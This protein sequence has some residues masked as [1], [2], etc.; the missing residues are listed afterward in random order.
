MNHKNIYTEA[1]KSAI[2]HGDGPAVVFAGPGSGK[3]FVLTERIFYMIYTLGIKPEHILVITFTKAA[4]KQMKARFYNKSKENLPITFKTFHAFFYQILSQSKIH[5]HKKIIS[6][7]EKMQII[8]QII[9]LYYS[10]ESDQS[11]LIKEISACLSNRYH[12]S[13]NNIY[14][15]FSEKEMHEMI[16]F[17]EEEKEKINRIDFTDLVFLSLGKLK[18]DPKFL[19]VIQK[20]YPYILIDEFQDIT[21]EQY[22]IICLIASKSKNIFIV[23]D[24]D[25]SIYKF[26]GSKSNCMRKFICDFVGT[27]KY[28]L[29]MNFRSGGKIIECSRNLI[30]HNKDRINYNSKSIKKDIGRVCIKNFHSNVEEYNYIVEQIKIFAEK[31]KE[32][33]QLEVGIITRTK[34]SWNQIQIQLLNNQIEV[35]NVKLNEKPVNSEYILDILAY[36]N[37]AKN[38]NERKDFIRI[39]NK[40]MRYLNMKIFRDERISFSKLK[41]EF[42]EQEKILQ[43]LI[44]FENQIRFI[45]NMSLHG[46]IHFI[47]KAVGYDKYAKEHMLEN[48]ENYLKKMNEL[49]LLEDV[50]KHCSSLDE[51]G[52]QIDNF[53]KKENRIV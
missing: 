46:A 8:K 15:F 7:K 31:S 34:S 25:Q 5:M 43:E 48:R 10:N 41:D 20:Q 9:Y 22:E 4:A 12:S 13:Q 51:L 47:R 23:G 28:F 3:T 36:L 33:K 32:L 21:L 49:D 18:H 40:P 30:M 45:R 53:T 38:G 17:Y 52:M 1:Q 27:K 14:S 42:I 6:D 37:F 39:V 29:D 26:C 35:K 11:E 2:L 16:T 50:S 19:E 44:K 24:E